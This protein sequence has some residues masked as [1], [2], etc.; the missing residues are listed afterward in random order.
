MRDPMPA[1]S[2]LYCYPV[3]SCRGIAL[4]EALLDERGIVHD[5][6]FM[7]VDA[8][9]RQITQRGTPA[10]AWITTAVAKAG[11]RLDFPRL[12][13]IEVPWTDPNR[14]PRE[15]T[16]WRDAVL[17][18]DAGDAA[19]A[20]LSDALRQPCRLVAIGKGSQRTVPLA[21]IPA[22]HQAMVDQSV[23]VAFADAF[24]LLLVSEESLRDLN[25]RLD[26]APPLGMDRFRPNLVLTGC[27]FPYAEDTWKTCQ[28]G[29]VRLFSAGPC[30]RCVIT[31]TDQQTL[32]RGAEPLRT[33]AKYRRSP[34]GEVVF[35]Q[36]VIHAQPG[37]CLRVGDAVL[38]DA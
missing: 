4:K 8:E 12:G 7:I 31:T 33:L 14:K 15:V 37:A 13:E 10:M 6:E 26:P 29:D 18:D 16:V 3:K 20:W 30:G 24:P 17:A 28:V 27:A 11:L 1:L 22:A 23:S 34:A 32:A 2:A 19:A 38:P 35:G 5:R 21:R 25:E 36:N 9:N